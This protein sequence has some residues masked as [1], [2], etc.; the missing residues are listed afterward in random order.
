[1]SFDWS[2]Y[3]S[4]AQELVGQS[5]NL[6]AGQEARSRAAI[7]RA[8]YAAFCECRNYLW[9]SGDSEEE[10]PR[11]SKVHQF[12]KNEFVSSSNVMRQSVGRNLDRLRIKRNQADYDDEISNLPKNTDLSLNLAKQVISNL[13][14]L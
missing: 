2:E 7:S 14:K 9:D 13:S 8:Y 6:P 5:V 3:F 10:R 12:V 1:M 11:G 4:L